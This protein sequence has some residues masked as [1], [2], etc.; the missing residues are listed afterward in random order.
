[1]NNFEIN[2]TA[3]AEENFSITTELTEEQV[4]EVLTPIVKLERDGIANY[5]NDDLLYALQFAYPLLET[6]Y[7]EQELLITI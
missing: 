3:Y 5:D 2:T 6:K 7:S 4:I 1:M